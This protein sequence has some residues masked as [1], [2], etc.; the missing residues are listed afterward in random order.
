MGQ[1]VFGAL[2]ALLSLA[3]LVVA[4]RAQ[5]GTLYVAGLLVFAL[6][7]GLNY[8]LIAKNTGHPPD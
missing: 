3:G 2:M 5:D 6:G 4:S 1:W 8:W 7:I